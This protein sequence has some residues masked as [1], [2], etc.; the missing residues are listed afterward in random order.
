MQCK[1]LKGDA[2]GKVSFWLSIASFVFAA[3]SALV[4]LIPFMIDSPIIKKYMERVDT[5]VIVLTAILIAMTIWVN[6]KVSDNERRKDAVR[7]L[8]LA[9]SIQKTLELRVRARELEKEVLRLEQGATKV[10]AHLGPRNLN[11]SDSD[12][13]VKIL[14]GINFPFKLDTVR[15]GDVEA[16]EFSRQIKDILE[17][18]DILKYGV[19]FSSQP[20][21][22]GIILQARDKV[23]AREIQEAFYQFGLIV[24]YE[25][26]PELNGFAR[27]SIGIKPTYKE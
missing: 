6:K 26:S 4:K 11:K 7:D 14:A 10:K 23:K 9:Q 8:K 15:G 13:L 27:M 12:K 17:R 3:I 1:N 24:N 16:T 21:H 2:L 20:K 25:Y 18:A 5:S 22:E 19:T